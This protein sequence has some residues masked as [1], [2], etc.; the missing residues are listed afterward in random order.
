MMLDKHG[1][2]QAEDANVHERSIYIQAGARESFHGTIEDAKVKEHGKLIT[3]M[4]IQKIVCFQIVRFSAG[5]VT[6]TQGILEDP[7]R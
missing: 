3:K 6:E 4:V 1:Q 5:H 7:I 2:E